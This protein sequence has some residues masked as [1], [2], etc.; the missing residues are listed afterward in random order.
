LSQLASD[1]KEHSWSHFSDWK[2]AVLTN[3]A[4]ELFRNEVARKTGT[5]SKPTDTGFRSYAQNRLSIN[6]DAQEICRNITKNLE[7]EV[8]TVGN[9]GPEKGQ[10]ECVTSFLFHDGVVRDSHYSP[11]KAIHKTS[12]ADFTRA[13]K[14]IASKA[15][16]DD[17]F[18][19]VS[20]LRAVEDIDKIE[21]VYEL[22]LFWR[23][24]TYPKMSI[25]PRMGNAQC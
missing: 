11:I 5:L 12:L 8:E 16:S 9:L 22:L 18:D 1:L 2:S 23:R 15:L 14:K 21:S 10:L 24:F 13:V 7:D 6:R 3:S 17:L 4:S 25:H 19:S 20:A